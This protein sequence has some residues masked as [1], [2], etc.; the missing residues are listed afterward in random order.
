MEGG[1]LLVAGGRILRVLSGPASV[2]RAER[3]A[4]RAAAR[5]EEGVLTA[6]FV[7]AHA[8]LDLGGLGGRLPPGSDF[9]AWVRGLLALRARRGSSALRRDAIRGADRLLATGTTT[10]GDVD[11]TG[12]AL[13][14]LSR[15]PLRLRQYREVLDARDP[16]RTAVA[17]RGLARALPRRVR[18]LEGIS[19]HA[20]F[21]ASE[22]LLAGCAALARRRG[23][24]ISIHW[25]ETPF[26]LEYLERGRGPLAAVLGTSPGRRGLDLLA[27]AGLLGPRTS[28]VHG[29]R[30]ARG[31]P[32]RISAAG[33]TLV[34]CPGS[35]AFF[36]REPFP[37]E[38]YRRARARLALG[39]DSLASNADLD[40]RREMALL[41]GAAPWLPPAEVW[42]L[43]TEGGARAVAMEG[44]VGALAPG[45]WAD[46]VLHSCAG[47][48]PRALLEELTLGRSRIAGVWIAGR[49]WRGSAPARA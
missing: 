10:A 18:R 14:A 12:A 23:A 34:H 25:A 6:G 20:P 40:L 39:T 22:E 8:H 30:P 32:A 43:A 19:P 46:L 2:R 44:E 49:R 48:S 13:A 24:A 7:D 4:G 38:R 1:G 3:A 11:S 47:S 21:S 37:I 15:H 45:A 9:A 27:E 33:A 31:D 16:E 28:L 26:E 36:G 35:H 5:L 42:T 29:N 17:L 41:R